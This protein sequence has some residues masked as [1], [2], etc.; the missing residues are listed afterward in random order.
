MFEIQSTWNGSKTHLLFIGSGLSTIQ[1]NEKGW[2]FWY[3]MQMQMQMETNTIRYNLKQ[4][5]KYN[6]IEI[7]RI[8][9]S[10][11]N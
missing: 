10:S 9:K 11:L 5:N 1:V 6:I 8:A 7:T 2:I 4:T 3:K